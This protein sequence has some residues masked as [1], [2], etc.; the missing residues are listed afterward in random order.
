[1]NQRPLT[2]R[3]F[4]IGAACLCTAAVTTACAA[5]QQFVRAEIENNRALVP[6]EKLSL[7]KSNIV[8]V[9]PLAASLALDWITGDEIADGHWRALLL[10]CTHRGCNVAPNHGGYLCPCHDSRFDAEGIV[11]VGPAVDP[12]SE[13]FCA[14]EGEAL[15]VTLPI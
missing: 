1:M 9:A 14:T 5:S 15:Y 13:L 11:L 12:L 4:L 6:L 8:Y 7:E 2:R 3:G 10:V